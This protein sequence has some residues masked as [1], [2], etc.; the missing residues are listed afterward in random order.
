MTH[1]AKKGL[2][3]LA[4]AFAAFYLLTQPEGAANAIEGAVGAILN[5]FDQILRFVTALF[6]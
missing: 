2:T 4:V 5:G 3:L 1:V 6:N